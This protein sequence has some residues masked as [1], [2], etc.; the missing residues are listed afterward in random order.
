VI[1]CVSL[2]LVVVDIVRF[3]SQRSLDKHT[4]RLESQVACRSHLAQ[5]RIRTGSQVTWYASCTFPTSRP[6]RFV[7]PNPI[8]K[9]KNSLLDAPVSELLVSFYIIPA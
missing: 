1:A 7:A 2:P 8:C 9:L 3:A 5:A 6:E 4:Q